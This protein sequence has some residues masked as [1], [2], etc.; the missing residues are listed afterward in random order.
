MAVKKKK[1]KKNKSL[2]LT[3]NAV[4]IKCCYCDS[5]DTCKY[6]E[7]KEATEKLGIVTK[8]TMTPNKKKTT[9]QQNKKTC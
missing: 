8:C 7:R 5:K 6:K 9:S 3:E 1:L 4:K 2:W